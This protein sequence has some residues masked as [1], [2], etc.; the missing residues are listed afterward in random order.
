VQV[1]EHYQISEAVR[2]V[3]QQSQGQALGDL[4]NRLT[5]EH[6]KKY[7]ELEKKYDAVLKEL[8]EFKLKYQILEEKYNELINKPKA[9]SNN[10]STAPSQDLNRSKK[11]SKNKNHNVNPSSDRKQ[12]ERST[13]EPVQNP[14]KQELCEPA[15]CNACGESLTEIAGDFNEAR[16]V[17]DVP[18]VELEI[19]EYI[20]TK[21]TCNCGHYNLGKFPDHVTHT[22]QYGP[23]LQSIVIDLVIEH[24]LPYERVC[25]LTKNLFSSG[26]SEA[27]VESFLERAYQKALTIHAGIIEFLKTCEIVGSDETTVNENGKRVY[28]WTW[29][30]QYASFFVRGPGR[31]F[32]VIEKHFLAEFNGSYLHDDYGAQNKVNAKV[33]QHCHPHI[34]R[35]LEYCIDC[36]DKDWAPRVQELLYK[37]QRARDIIWRDGFPENLRRVVQESFEKRLDSLLAE[38]IDPK[39][40]KSL[41]QQKRRLQ[42]RE[43]IF[44]FLYDPDLPFDNNGSERAQRNLKIHDKVSGCFRSINGLQRHLCLLSIIETGKKQGMNPFTVCENLVAGT[45]K[46]PWMA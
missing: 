27:T 23:R 43:K 4:Y 21:K 7:S 9:N 44:P 36:G 2:F 17:F 24:K 19:T 40:K 5:A 38:T 8:A 22:V 29:Q 32:N 31:G 11:N 16:Q 34:T 6:N 35:K 33:H 45:L 13:L 3:G 12:R 1:L 39:Y 26:L 15:I 28:T 10:S 46:F 25:K 14:D 42:H 18:P 30:N 20:Q 41:T 37:S